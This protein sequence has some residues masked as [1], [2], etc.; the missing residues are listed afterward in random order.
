MWDTRVGIGVGYQGGDWCGMPGWGLV[1]DARVGI[2][3]GCQGGDWCGGGGGADS[4]NSEHW[5]KSYLEA[6]NNRDVG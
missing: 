6:C 4:L 1:W 3:V 5:D 2:G